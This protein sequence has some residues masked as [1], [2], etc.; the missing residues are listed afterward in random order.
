MSEGSVHPP[1]DLGVHR[2]GAV[3]GMEDPLGGA[4]AA[5]PMPARSADPPRPAPLRG[6][7]SLGFV[8]DVPV[9]VTVELGRR[10]VR[11]A[12]V[13]R[14]GPGSV[15]ELDKASGEPLDLYVNN[16]LI[17]RG[18]AVVIGERYGIRLT[19]VVINEERSGEGG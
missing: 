10:Q 17:A 12:E 7:D 19:E 9:A 16:R 1:A 3:P 4:R 6:I 13:L 15:L 14:L 11:I 8:M 5:G 18:E 2:A